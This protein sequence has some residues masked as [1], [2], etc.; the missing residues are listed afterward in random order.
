MLPRG[1]IMID[2]KTGSFR[3]LALS[4]W[5]SSLLL[6]GSTLALAANLDVSAPAPGQ[7]YDVSGN[8]TY[9]QVNAGNAAGETGT[10]NVNAGNTLTTGS[11][12]VT[13]TTL[14]NDPT[15]T[16]TINVTGTGAI[17]TDNGIAYIGNTGIGAINVTAGGALN[18][19]DTHIGYGAG[20][21][22]SVLVDGTGSSWTSTGDINVGETGPGAVTI[23]NGATLNSYHLFLNGLTSTFTVTG[24]GTT[25]TNTGGANVG[26]SN[27]ANEQFIISDG[28]T[29][30]LFNIGLYMSVGS[31]V[32]IT[33]A[34]TTMTL[35]NTGD[36]LNGAWFT[37]NGGT[38]LLSDGATLNS[39]GGFIGS[40]GTD[41]ADMTVTGAGTVWNSTVRV[42]VGGSTGGAGDGVGK[43]TVSDGAVVNSATGGAGLDT[44]SDGTII[45]TGA[46]TLFHAQATPSISALGNF[47]VSYAGTSNVLVTDGAE[48]RVDNE[49]R[50]ATVAGS[51]GALVIGAE[52]GDPAA[53]PGIITTPTI[54]FGDGGG[55]IIF[56]HTSDGLTFS[57]VLTGN[58]YIEQVAGT[59]ILTGASTGYTGSTDVEGGTLIVNGTLGDI[60]SVLQTYPGATLAGTG[61]VGGKLYNLGNVSAG[62]NGAGT[63]NVGSDFVAFTGTTLSVEA[64]S[65]GSTAGLLAVGGAAYING[66]DVVLTNGGF[67][68]TQTYTIITAGSA[69]LGTYN[70][71]SAPYYAFVTP[72]LG[73]TAH[74]VDVSFVRNATAFSTY[75]GTP[76]EIATANAIDNLGGGNALYDAILG[77]NAASAGPAFNYLSGEI[78]AGVKSGIL[79]GSHFVSDNV[80][81]HIRKVFGWQ[82]AGPA[83][84]VVADAGDGSSAFPFR[85]QDT[86]IWAQTFGSWGHTNG[87]GNASK[88]KHTSGGFVTGVD[89]QVSDAARIGIFAGYQHSRF[90]ESAVA[91]SAGVD[92]FEMGLYGGTEVSGFGLRGGA[93]FTLHNID[94]SRTVIAGILTNHLTAS[95]NAT[96][97][98]VFGEVGYAIPSETVTFEPFASIA[99]MSVRTEGYSETGGPAALTVSG[100]TTNMGTTT[101][102]SRASV[103]FKLASTPARLTATAGWRHAFGTLNTNTTAA[104]SGGT[105]FTV[106]GTPMARDTG[107]VGA[108][109]GMALTAST[110]L[111]VSYDGE[112]GNGANNNTVQARIAYAF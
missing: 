105:P 74:N 22:G 59:T 3:T 17:F 100:D 38:M 32:T 50:I 63:L 99:Y 106:S 5:T 12:G 65:D 13:G 7:T 82:G 6:S 19:V 62:Q 91:S 70:S 4:L 52:W 78:S 51:T 10:I 2:R 47:Y 1:N 98:Q 76:N 18:T 54:V 25:W 11:T 20:S 41:L 28:A 111:G 108:N 90:E 95:T 44:S 112:F 83:P 88:L 35:E 80:L 23:S 104:F 73:Y 96:T 87:D 85:G 101:L 61:T 21:D 45:L 68:P 93:S 48:L 40:G 97:A 94:T 69:V 39:D 49:L 109:L 103:D 31:N 53:A 72:V 27:A 81:D 56:N 64:S 8:E 29:A 107:I 33:G 102:G 92:S 37:S 36:P 9:D 71:V 75:A 110:S 43:L 77:L 67:L 66:G 55:T 86:A 60:T 79:G 30:N 42:Y 26:L 14:G 24:A 84:K 57:P 58:G 16:G 89:K 34:G 15:A 46:G